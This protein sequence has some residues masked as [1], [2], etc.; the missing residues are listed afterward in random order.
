M[1]DV[2]KAFR[3]WKMMRLTEVMK[4]RE[5]RKKMVRAKVGMCGE[6]IIYCNIENRTGNGEEV[7]D[8][9]SEEWK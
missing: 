6:D 5:I 1:E 7:E 9:N 3:R 4:R 2:D 8:D